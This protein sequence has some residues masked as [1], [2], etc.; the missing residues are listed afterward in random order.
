MNQNKALKKKDLNNNNNNNN[1]QYL[2]LYLCLLSISL[3]TYSIILIQDLNPDIW[4][5]LT[6]GKNILSDGFSTIDSLTM[7]E[8]MHCIAQQ[9]LTDIIY[10]KIYDILGYVGLNIIIVLLG[11][12][13]FSL[14]FCITKKITNSPG[15]TAFISCL[16]LF[17]AIFIS[18][19]PHM[20]SV[21][22]L[23]LT[24]YVYES[25]FRGKN[26]LYL[27]PIISLVLINVHAAFWPV[28]FIFA[29]PY[30]FEAFCGK[31]IVQ[32]FDKK[33]KFK[34][35]IKDFQYT[36]VSKLK[37]IVY[38]LS[39]FPI[40]LINPFGL[41]A[42]LYGFKSTNN[43]V[44]NKI[45]QEMRSL[46]DIDIDFQDFNIVELFAELIVPAFVLLII[47]GVAISKN[48][49]I[50]IRNVCL[51][52]G[53]FF[54]SC[55]SYKYVLLFIIGL[56]YFARESVPENIKLFKNENDFK[57]KI[58]AALCFVIFMTAFTGLTFY[59]QD[60][61]ILGQEEIDYIIKTDD[62]NDIKILC[63]NEGGYVEFNGFASYMDTRMEVFIEKNNQKEDL[64]VEAEQVLFFDADKK[65]YEDFFNKY[66]FDYILAD[67]GWAPGIIEYI[68]SSGEW[69][70]VSESDDTGIKC[71]LYKNIID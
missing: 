30:L 15:K 20:I 16:S 8:N 31:Y 66:D 68:E 33:E 18:P 58:I 11:L 70:K 49:K 43:T 37:L 36:S 27:L 13:E 65:I 34:K 17:Y 7:H 2:F 3:Y 64:L 40:A 21:I 19:R 47:I 24:L 71:T 48:K 25:Y 54:M 1:K 9:W 51:L 5:M 59:A 45:T 4:W 38:T 44:I 62:R 55:I 46:F 41:E 42:I 63:F 26:I 61:K 32:F 50:S 14:V 28:M 60:S 12:I 22:L 10:Y 29:L 53:L 69:E 39:V 52:I 6:I 57:K 35:Y 23:T 56:P 67:Q